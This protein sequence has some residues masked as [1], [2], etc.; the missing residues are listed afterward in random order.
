M[1]LFGEIFRAFVGHCANEMS[2][3]MNTMQNSKGMSNDELLRGYLDKSNSAGERAGY[4]ALL[5]QN[6]ENR[7]K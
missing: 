5:K 7:N 6:L 2:K 4:G 1:G 3:G